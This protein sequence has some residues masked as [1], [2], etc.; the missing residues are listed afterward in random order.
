SM[1]SVAISGDGEYL[2]VADFQGPLKLFDLTTGKLISQTGT[3]GGGYA[4]SPDG[5][6][7]ASVV[8]NTNQVKVWAIKTGKELV[9]WKGSAHV[10]LHSVR[11][12]PDGT[13][14]AA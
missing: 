6:F 14:L 2:E 9:T 4:V 8:T 10:Y 1:P 11:F 12:S 3:I 5:N 7:L 13:K